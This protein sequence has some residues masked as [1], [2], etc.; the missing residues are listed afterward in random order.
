MNFGAAS[1]F[2]NK[3]VEVDGIV[4][5]SKK[6]S[7]IYEDLKTELST[8]KITGFERQVKFILI[9][10]QYENVTV[11]DKKGRKVEKQK[12]VEHACTY[13]ADFVV[14]HSDGSVVVVDVKGSRGLD[15]KY[16]LKR[17]LLLWVHKLRIMEV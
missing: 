9:P 11:E 16:P 15:Q 6:E 14:T 3:K 7:R 10:A 13:V 17:K 2:H 5:D 4:F 8:G 12:I 1:K